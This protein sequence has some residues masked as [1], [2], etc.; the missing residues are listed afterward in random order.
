MAAANE[1]CDVF[2]SYSRADSRHAEEIDSVLR[3]KGLKSFF[4]R[5]NLEPGLP[6]VRKLEKAIGEAKTAI[7]LIGPGGFGNTQQYERELAVIRQT[8]EPSFRVIPVVLP[9]AGSD[10]PFDFLQNLTWIDF[11]RAEKISGAPAELDRL[12]RAI[13]GG[14]TAG[15]GARQAICPWRGLDAFRE[16]DSAFFFRSRQRGRSEQ[17][18]RPTGKQGPRASLRHGGGTIGERQVV[19]RLWI[20]ARAS[21]RAE[22]VL[23]CLVVQART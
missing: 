22:S 19:A 2:I 15:E 11:S 14:P 10:L 12:L 17:P 20:G 1:T 21:A 8:R 13:Q 16:E 23:D 3:D 4:D 5:H 6:W 9:G 18:Y 7:V